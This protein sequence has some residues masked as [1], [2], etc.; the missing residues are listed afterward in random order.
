MDARRSDI[1]YLTGFM[2]CGKSTVAPRLAA[3][4]GF[5]CLDVDAEVERRTGS[6]VSGIFERSGERAFRDLEREVLF[7]TSGTR[8]L[9]VALGG[10]TI[11]DA[12]NFAFVR[13]T[14]LLVYLRADFG[15]L[16]GRLRTKEDRP[17][18]AHRGAGG[19]VPEEELRAAM[20]RLL[21]LREPWY[22]RADIIVDADPADAEAT[23]AGIA[24]AVARLGAT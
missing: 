8:D 21:A 20:K 23:A 5:G 1:I 18:I 10:G 17:L 14:G 16:F 15:T 24:E 4:L 11:A 7:G 13:R 2:G 9:V 3:I 12:E 6:T 22:G 19:R